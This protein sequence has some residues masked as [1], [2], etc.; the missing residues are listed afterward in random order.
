[1]RGLLRSLFGR[2]GVK[3]PRY[4]MPQARNINT[5][6]VVRCSLWEAM[7]VKLDQ[8]ARAEHIAEVWAARMTEQ[9]GGQWV[10]EVSIYTT[11]DRFG[12]TRRA[13]R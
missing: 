4:L 2:L 8:Q 12:R 1:M 6:T 9:H 10:P 7:H 13:D 3:M 5:D 11:V